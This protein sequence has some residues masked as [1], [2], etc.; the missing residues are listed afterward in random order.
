MN[1]VVFICVYICSAWQSFFP[2]CKTVQHYT[3]TKSGISN[4]KRLLTGWVYAFINALGN[5]TDV[6]FF[7]SIF[8]IGNICSSGISPA[9]VFL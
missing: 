7:L 1:V 2:E 6:L 8:I 3:T 5:K 9:V 4:C